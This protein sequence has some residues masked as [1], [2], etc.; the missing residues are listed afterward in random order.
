MA[1]IAHQYAV[2]LVT[3]SFESKGTFK[4]HLV[5]GSLQLLMLEAFGVELCTRLVQEL[6]AQNTSP[7]PALENLVFESSISSASTRRVNGQLD[8]TRCGDP[9]DLEAP[10][11]SYCFQNQ[12]KFCLKTIGG[13][14]QIRMWFLG[15]RVHFYLTEYSLIFIYLSPQIILAVGTSNNTY[16]LLS[17]FY[18]LRNLSLTI[19]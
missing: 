12:W 13:P 2:T 19:L 3:E 15:S 16:F 14:K 8:L 18:W 10:L 17:D 6:T 4:C 7:G 9:L 5:Q 11:L 1:G